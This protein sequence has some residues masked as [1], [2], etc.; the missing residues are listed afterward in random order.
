MIRC[1]HLI[2]YV[3]LLFLTNYEWW[4]VSQVLS[5]SIDICQM[6]IQTFLK[7]V[8]WAEMFV[9][10]LSIK[11][12]DILI[13]WRL[14]CLYIKFVFSTIISI[15]LIFICCTLRLLIMR[16]LKLCC[17]KHYVKR[18]VLFCKMKNCPMNLMDDPCIWKM[19]HKGILQQH[20]SMQ[21]TILCI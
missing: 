10:G 14:L 3:I 16:T 20:P 19:C 5:L 7:K 11:F 9:P 18:F 8:H 1:I 4:S 2:F 15:T 12:M 17:L 21:L 6:F 13:L